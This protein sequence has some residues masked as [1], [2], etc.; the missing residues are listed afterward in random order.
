MRVD[1]TLHAAGFQTRNP[2][3]I[4]NAQGSAPRPIPTLRKT[5]QWITLKEIVHMEPKTQPK[6]NKAKN[7]NNT[8]TE[9]YRAG[10]IRVCLAL[11][12]RGS[13]SESGRSS[14][15]LQWYILCNATGTHCRA[16]DNLAELFLKI[17]L[18]WLECQAQQTTFSFLITL[19]WHL[20]TSIWRAPMDPI[21]YFTVKVEP[22]L[23]L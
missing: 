12:C 23:A 18:P 17:L 20:Q 2:A 5:D 16:H 22:R 1:A 19:F 9:A 14:T 11:Y 3:S 4:S 10:P 15:A 21:S 7:R 6:P 8:E 13:G